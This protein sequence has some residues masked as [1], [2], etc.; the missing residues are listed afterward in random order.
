[1]NKTRKTT[2]LLIFLFGVFLSKSL[3]AYS[4]SIDEAAAYANFIQNLINN[5]SFKKGGALCSYG[6]DAVVRS[7]AKSVKKIDSANL[8][9]TPSHCK[10]VYIASDNI[11]GLRNYLDSL[12]E[13]NIMTISTIDE[14]VESG[15]TIQVQMGRRDF[16]LI[17][18]VK[19]LNA[20]QIKLDTLSTNLIVY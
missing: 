8:N 7:F 3:L 20:A 10:A 18:D 12:S 15:G 13:K 1:M 17:V 4:V 11:P 9:E 19:A 14:F 6:N 5:S 2:T 16:E